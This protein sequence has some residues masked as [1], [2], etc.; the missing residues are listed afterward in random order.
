MKTNTTRK[1]IVVAVSPINGEIF[2][3]TLLND[4]V[5]WS[6]NKHDVTKQALCAV[7][8]YVAFNGGAVV[9]E[10]DGIPLC[11]ITVEKVP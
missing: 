11:Q 9:L 8:G 5:T 1:P 3:G 2:A 7:A 4:G 10:E 6:S